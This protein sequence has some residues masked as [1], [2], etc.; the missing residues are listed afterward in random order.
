MEIQGFN[1][2]D[3]PIPFADS[4]FTQTTNITNGIVKS[5]F[6]RIPITFSPP[7]I[8]YNLD[9]S[10]GPIKVYN[11]PAE[12][13]RKLRIKFR[14]HNGLYVPFSNAEYSFMLEFFIYKPQINRQITN[15]TQQIFIPAAL[16]NF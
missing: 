14:F 4:Q 5:A 12:R 13:I 2:L 7:S 10:H 9:T 6:S 1:S 11:P 15:T 8:L 3:E 16:S